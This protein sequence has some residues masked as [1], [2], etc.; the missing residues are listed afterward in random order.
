MSAFACG[1]SL[2]WTLWAATDWLEG[3]KTSDAVGFW[4]GL[5]FALL[6]GLAWFAA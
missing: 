4:C 3:R 5:F 1:I 6:N 2:M